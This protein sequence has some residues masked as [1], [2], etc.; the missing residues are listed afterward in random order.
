MGLIKPSKGTI[1]I[2]GIPTDNEE[3][4]PF[5]S[6]VPQQPFLFNSTIL[7]NITMGKGAHVDYDYIDLLC[8]KLGLTEAMN[9]LPNGYDTEIQ[10]ESLRFSGGQ[11]QRLSIVR[12]LYS[13][14]QLLILDEATNQQNSML[15]QHI[16][17]F[18]KELTEKE[19]MSIISVSHT[20]NTEGFYTQSFKLEDK[21]LKAI[22]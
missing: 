2:D 11:K 18:L 16:F 4:L 10:H 3:F 9:S 15:E 7:E 22:G 19:K 12:V 20:K 21:K 8:E 17:S 5:V 6:Y 1:L 14:P 13:K